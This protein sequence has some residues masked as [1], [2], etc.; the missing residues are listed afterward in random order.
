MFV[1][2]ARAQT[3]VMNQPAAPSFE[4]LESVEPGDSG[5]GDR[6][7]AMD[8]IRRS[9]LDTEFSICI[10]DQS[11]DVSGP[12][13]PC[14]ASVTQLRQSMATGGKVDVVPLNHTMEN[15]NYG[16]GLITSIATAFVGLEAMGQPAGSQFGDFGNR[17]DFDAVMS[18]LFRQGQRAA[19]NN[20]SA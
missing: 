1:P 13:G 18:A 6:A 17:A 8:L 11:G 10:Y 3:C 15:A 5:S 19:G 7:S 12:T 9:L 20:P 16:I 4:E 2:V 14:N